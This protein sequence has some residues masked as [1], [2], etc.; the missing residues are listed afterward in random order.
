MLIS[1][2]LHFEVAA[3]SGNL[4]Q[5]QIFHVKRVL[6]KMIFNLCMISLHKMSLLE[7]RFS[8]CKMRF[9]SHKKR[10]Y[11]CEMDLA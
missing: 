8:P 2:N 5:D 10:F 6:C 1:Y 3:T 7:M 11:S 9:S 4:M